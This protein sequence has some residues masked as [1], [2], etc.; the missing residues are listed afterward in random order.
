MNRHR[1]IQRCLMAIVE[2]LYC[3]EYCS[4]EQTK[5][6]LSVPHNYFNIKFQLILKKNKMK[7]YLFVK[8]PILV[9]NCWQ[10]KE[11]SYTM[12]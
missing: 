6:F 8:M 11:E 9:E 10:Y 2:C 5:T 1:E 4:S 7:M 12:P 3:T